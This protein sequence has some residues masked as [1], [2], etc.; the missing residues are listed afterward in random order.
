[1]MNNLLN[2]F[3]RPIFQ[4]SKLPNLIQVGGQGC[5]IKIRD[6]GGETRAGGKIPPNT[7]FEIS[8]PSDFYALTYA[9][10]MIQENVLGAKHL[11]FN[12]RKMLECL[13]VWLNITDNW[14]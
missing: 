9:V 14:K 7:F 12:Y 3:S 10:L 1:M 2:I 8:G 11:L 4:I 13:P 6:S 5:I